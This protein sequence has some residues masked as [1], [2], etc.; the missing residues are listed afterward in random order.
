[1]NKDLGA[2]LRDR[3]GGLRPEPATQSQ[4][5]ALVPSAAALREL[6]DELEQRQ[7]DLRRAKEAAA[8]LSWLE[9]YGETSAK[10]KSISF[11]AR[12]TFASSCAGAN[13]AS[14]YLER[15][16]L[17]LSAVFVEAAADLARADIERVLPASA[18]EAPSGGETG[19]GSTVGESAVDA[20]GSETP[21]EPHHDQ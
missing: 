9:Q 2:S 21:K 11:E 18:I 20:E 8:A 12:F 5:K 3:A 4:P 17:A 19:T 10:D 1:M 6:T 16:A 15:A 14:D 7:R 13:Q